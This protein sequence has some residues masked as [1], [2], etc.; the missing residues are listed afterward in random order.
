MTPQDQAQLTK[1]ISALAD[2]NPAARFRV[3]IRRPVD[4][5]PGVMS[6]SEFAARCA[7]ARIEAE[8]VP[9]VVSGGDGV[10]QEMRLVRA[11]GRA[12][13]LLTVLRE[14]AKEPLD[15]PRRGPSLPGE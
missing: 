10:I 3:Q 7:Q 4:A 9:H 6:A 5:G 11:F 12:E 2:A 15:A 13:D 1:T 8:V 14:L